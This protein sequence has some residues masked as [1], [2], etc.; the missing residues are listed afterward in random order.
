MPRPAGRRVTTTELRPRRNA[1]AWVPATAGVTSSAIPYR[2]S[3][4]RSPR[5]TRAGGR[6]VR[7]SRATCTRDPSLE[8][9]LA[10]TVEPAT[11]R[12]AA[13]KPATSSPPARPLRGS[14]VG[15]SGGAAPGRVVPSVGAAGP[16]VPGISRPPDAAG[17]EEDDGDEDEGDDDGDDGGDDGGG[18]DDGG[19]DE[20]GAVRVR[21]GRGVEALGGGEV[22]DEPGS[23]AGVPGSA[24]SKK[25]GDD[26]ASGARVSSPE[27]PA[28]ATARAS[29]PRASAPR[30]GAP[31]SRARPVRT[32]MTHPPVAVVLWSSVST[33]GGS[34]ESPN[35]GKRGPRSLAARGSGT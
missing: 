8:T 31:A 20:G 18:D 12:T 11:G 4:S 32:D 29:A 15:R 27:H 21:D 13:G 34:R 25:P 30:V 22:A 7:A 24:V 17:S 3:R 5:S 28:G 1:A 16:G 14:G 33:A 9:L 10:V 19:A 35:C 26:A 2:P 6:S 23:V